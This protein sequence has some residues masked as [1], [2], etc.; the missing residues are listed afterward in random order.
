MRG[1]TIRL[2]SCAFFLASCRRVERVAPPVAMDA[3]GNETSVTPVDASAPAASSPLP[4]P[5]P[6]IA[7]DRAWV[8]AFKGDRT[9]AEKHALGVLTVAFLPDGVSGM[10][11]GVDDV[12]RIWDLRTGNLSTRHAG[13]R[14][15]FHQVVFTHDAKRALSAGDGL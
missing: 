9:F 11:S 13:A 15:K 7:A 3:G 5:G 6:P 10:S 14:F 8:S 1:A 2:M 4:N 12:A